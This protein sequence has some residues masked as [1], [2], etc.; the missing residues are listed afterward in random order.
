LGSSIG[1]VPAD[2]ETTGRRIHINRPTDESEKCKVSKVSG[3]HRGFSLFTQRPTTPFTFN[4][5][6]LR[7]TRTEP[8]EARPCRHGA[9]SSPRRDF[10]SGYRRSRIKFQQ[11]DK[12]LEPV[13]RDHPARSLREARRR[14]IPI[15]GALLSRLPPRSSKAST[16]GMNATVQTIGEEN[17][18]QCRREKDESFQSNLAT[19]GAHYW[20]KPPRLSLL[21]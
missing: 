12:T 19:R 17:A 21:C 7:Q 20:K 2:G 11:T 5:I 9:K 10:S 16:K 4:A 8:S 14:T 18:G 3:Q 1:I 13:C 15:D 6:S